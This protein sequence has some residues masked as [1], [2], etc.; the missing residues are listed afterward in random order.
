[1]SAPRPTLALPDKPSI[2][3][4]P[5]QNM[6]GD[7]DQEHFAD[8]M[9]E[10][11]IT[12]LSRMRW[13]FVIARNSTVTYKKRAVDVK[14]VGREL[15]VRYVLEG[16]VRRSGERVRIA[17]Q[18]IDTTS[19]N[20]IWADRY[21]GA[22]SDIFDLQ[23]RVAESVVGAIQPSILTAEMDRSARKRPDSLLAYDYVLRAL[24]L[25]WSINRTHSEKAQ[26][27]LERALSVEPDYP[28]ALSLAAW[29]H[30]QRVAYNWTD[31][32]AE[33]REIA[34]RLAQQAA[35]ISRD[36]PMVL[37]I[38]GAAHTI[39]RDF[40]IAGEHWSVRCRS[41]RIRPGHGIAAAGSASIRHS[42]ISQFNSSSG[43]SGSAPS[44][45]RVLSASSALQTLASSSVTMKRRSNG[46]KKA[47]T[48]SQRRP[49][50]FV[51]SFRH[52]SMRGAQRRPVT[53]SS[54]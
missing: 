49:G 9:V 44:I 51:C 50:N 7:A 40:Q 45:P 35:T 2:A 39:V 17:G 32:M 15:G 22:L 28:L 1:M 34:L 21:D 23:D 54:R 8:G 33:E 38:L 48:S 53:L 41:T 11:I 52:W 4:L 5:F 26:V 31:A 20:H 19:G 27:L 29:C 47:L 14:Q 3:V 18:L 30:A 25:V 46:L 24:P 42:Q 6:S 37:A 10:E 13:L 43:R 16:S 12:A 36:D